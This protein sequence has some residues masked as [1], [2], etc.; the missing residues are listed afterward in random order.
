MS[1]PPL[2]VPLSFLTVILCAVSGFSSQGRGI[3]PNAGQTLGAGDVTGYRVIVP[4]T[5]STHEELIRMFG[6]SRSSEGNGRK[7]QV[8][9]N[10]S[11]FVFP[12]F[13]GVER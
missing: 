13:E 7:T 10:L 6:D 1:P 4:R 8:F 9:G 12:S 2:P 11:S 5:A 3:Q